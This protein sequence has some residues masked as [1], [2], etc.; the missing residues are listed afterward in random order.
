MIVTEG[1]PLVACCSNA[2]TVA[3]GWECAGTPM[4]G[5]WLSTAQALKKMV[6][7]MPTGL[8][9]AK[10]GIND[11]LVKLGSVLEDALWDP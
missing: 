4:V 10:G 8:R 9:R 5:G 1:V 6:S 11:S 3:L 2:V 7:S